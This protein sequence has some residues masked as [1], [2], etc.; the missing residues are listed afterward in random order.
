MQKSYRTKNRI[1][2]RY[3]E[4]ATDTRELRIS[5]IEAQRPLKQPVKQERVSNGIPGTL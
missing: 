3:R 2:A 1:Q 4:P 5:R